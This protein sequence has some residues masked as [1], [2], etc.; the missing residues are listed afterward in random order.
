MGSRIL[1]LA[2]SIKKGGRCLAGIDVESGR[3]VR[4]VPSASVREVPNEA[5]IINGKWIRPGDLVS[6]ELGQNLPLRYHPEDVQ[7]ISDIKL[8]QANA[9]LE[10]A[11][12]LLNETKRTNQLL[13]NSIDR[14]SF[15]EVAENPVTN[16]LGLAFASQITFFNNDFG[17]HKASFVIGGNR[18]VLSQTDDHLDSFETIAEGLVCISLA[19][20]YTAT[21]SHHKLAAGF[22]PVSQAALTRANYEANLFRNSESLSELA[23]KF[24]NLPIHVDTDERLQ[25]RIWFYQTSLVTNCPKCVATKH[26][27]FRAHEETESV[28][29]VRV[30]HRFAL[31]CLNCGNVHSTPLDNEQLGKEIRIQVEKT[32][33][34][35]QLCPACLSD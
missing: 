33:P 25:N 9:A 13:T 6:V 16:S 21:Q 35:K 2:N 20:P 22:L 23:S 18:W 17:S 5:T 14:I 30:L 8:I 26:E 15:L 19:E 3:W 4:P 11:E 31:L 29:G 24:T 1:V 7:L 32:K 34:V 10:F 12:L 27:V 28:K